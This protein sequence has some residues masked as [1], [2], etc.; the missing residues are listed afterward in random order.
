MQHKD[1]KFRAQDFNIVATM[2]DDGSCP[3]FDKAECAAGARIHVHPYH[4]AR[5]CRKQPQSRQSRREP[6]IEYAGR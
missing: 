4:R 2:F 6:G 5:G 3:A 1:E